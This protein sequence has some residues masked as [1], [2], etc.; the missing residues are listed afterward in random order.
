MLNQS[1]RFFS[2]ASSPRKGRV[3]TYDAFVVE[4]EPFNACFR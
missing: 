3:S 4:Y 2:E 1:V